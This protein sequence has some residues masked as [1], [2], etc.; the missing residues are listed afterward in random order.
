MFKFLKVNE[1]KAISCHLRVDQN[2]PVLL[3]DPL[4]VS[5]GKKY[6]KTPA[7]VA[8]RYQIQRGVI[9]ISKSYNPERIKDN[10]KVFDFELSTEDM[11]AIDGLNRNLRYLEMPVYVYL[12]LW[13]K[14]TND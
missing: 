11:K 8:L 9:V 5:I 14:N 6:K 3:E 10:I 4:L 2:S 12:V 1:S 7:H 13:W